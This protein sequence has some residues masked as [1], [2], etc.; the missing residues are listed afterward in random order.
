VLAGPVLRLLCRQ[1]GAQWDERARRRNIGGARL[2]GFNMRSK[3]GPAAVPGSD[4]TTVVGPVLDLVWET[5]IRISP[6]ALC[7]SRVR[8][9]EAAPTPVGP[10]LTSVQSLRL[11]SRKSSCAVVRIAC[12]R[13]AEFAGYCKLCPPQ[14]ARR[15]RSTAPTSQLAG[16][17]QR[18]DLPGTA[19]ARKGAEIRPCNARRTPS[20]E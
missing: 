15:P 6:A 4:A 18:L 19:F 7:G 20:L 8:S 3:T 17:W 12:G 11:T 2:G 10:A 1:H 5:F 16:P 13:A 14:H 9:A